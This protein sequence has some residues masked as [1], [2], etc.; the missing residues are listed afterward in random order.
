MPF[1][2]KFIQRFNNVQLPESKVAPQT[3]RRYL[4]NGYYSFGL[5]CSTIFNHNIKFKSFSSPWQR[6]FNSAIL[7]YNLLNVNI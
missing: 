1:F 6:F 4:E 5:V 3:F 7:C 2:V